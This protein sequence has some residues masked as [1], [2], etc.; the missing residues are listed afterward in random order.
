MEPKKLFTP[1]PT[2]VPW[3]VLEKMAEPLVHHRTEEF[4]TIFREAVANLQYVY[5]TKSPVLI[6]TA[7][8]SGAM[9]AAMVNI[10]R[11]G[12]KALVTVV[13]KFSER[14]RELGQAYGLDL[15]LLEDKWGNPID[16][17]RVKTALEQNPDIDIVFTTH[18]ETSTGVLQ[19]VKTISRIAH[20]RR[21][22]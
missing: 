3:Q 20:S 19:D 2:Q 7:S 22:S 15:V 8:G 4:R 21:P 13:G 9:E 6:L 10:T 16:P 1:G 11:P 12:E 5:K 17:D 18:C 14:W